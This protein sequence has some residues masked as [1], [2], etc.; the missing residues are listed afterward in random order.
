MSVLT[1]TR[2]AY[3]RYTTKI[4]IADDPTVVIIQRQTRVNK[5]GGGY[6]FP[7]SPIA[8]QIFRFVNQDISTGISYGSD[9]GTARKFDYVLVGEHNADIDVNDTWTANGIQY[10]VDA[11]IPNNGFETRAHVTAFAIEPEHG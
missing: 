3:L 9:D 2:Q 6:D 8:A 4:Y 11:I 5:G 10:K 1:D 7:K